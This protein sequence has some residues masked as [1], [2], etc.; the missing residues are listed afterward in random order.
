MSQ[1]FDAEEH[2]RLSMEARAEAERGGD[3]RLIYG[4]ELG[5]A[6]HDPWRAL[7]IVREM[8]FDFVLGSYHQ[9]KGKPDFYFMDYESADE[10]H[11]LIGRYLDELLEMIELGCFDVLGHLTYPL[12]YMR[13]RLPQADIGFGAHRE[14]TEAVLRALIE[15]GKGIELNVSGLWR[16]EG[17]PMPDLDLLKRFRALGG[18]IVTVGSDAHA[19]ADV[20]RGIADGYGLLR[21][22]G[23]RHVAAYQERKVR[24]ERLD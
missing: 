16:G 4:I 13:R 5:E 6:T 7:A 19:A 3:V 17:T 8:P 24:F 23:F 14:K 21:E 18:E 12:R 15:A 11:A 2:Y 1:A 9:L 10:C 22:A 20:G